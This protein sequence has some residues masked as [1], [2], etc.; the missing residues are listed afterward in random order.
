[1]DSVLHLG[2]ILLGMAR[3]HHITQA[4]SVSVR[5]ATPLPMQVDGGGSALCRNMRPPRAR[6]HV[7]TWG[8]AFQYAYRRCGPAVPVSLGYSRMPRIPA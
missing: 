2:R 7:M 8:A 4:S 1:M 3:P 6:H 5:T